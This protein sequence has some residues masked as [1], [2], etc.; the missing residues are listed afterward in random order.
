MTT[1]ISTNTAP[2]RGLALASFDDAFRFSKMVSASEFAPKDFRGKP[3]SCLLAIQH[4]SEVGLSP[5]QSLQSIAVINGR[6]T[7]WG[8]A[9]LA[10]VQSSPVCEYVREYTEG[11]GDGLVAVCEAKR[12]GYPQPTVVR[13]S[14]ADAKRAGLAGKSGPW[15]QYPAR[16]LT[17][18]ARGFALRNAFAD[19]LRGLITAEEAQDYQTAE[20]TPAGARRKN[21]GCCC[22]GGHGQ[23][24]ASNRRSEER[25]TVAA[26]L[27]DG[28]AA[29]RRWLLHGHA[30]QRVDGAHRH[31][32]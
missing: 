28:A 3:E 11:E 2:A 16:M 9:A 32:H 25:R 29:A 13:F 26:A 14:M 19:A 24:P 30:G 7:I 1:E 21:G 8:D 27:V 5:M 4:G 23:S 10:L 22:D 12:K 31:Q 6:P 20:Q 17:L 18:R 15:S